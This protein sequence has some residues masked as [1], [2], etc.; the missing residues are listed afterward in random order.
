[1]D[2]DGY[3]PNETT[4]PR[5]SVAEGMA[6]VTVGTGIDPDTGLTPSAHSYAFDAPIEVMNNGILLSLVIHVMP[7]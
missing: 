2:A 1:M 7:K 6:A 3:F 5:R 4:G